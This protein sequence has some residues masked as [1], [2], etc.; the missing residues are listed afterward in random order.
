MLLLQVT[1][2]NRGIQVYCQRIFNKRLV[3]ENIDSFIT[4]FRL[5]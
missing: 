3:R 4:M 5:V 1:V 2:F